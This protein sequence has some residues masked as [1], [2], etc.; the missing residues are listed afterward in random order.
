MAAIF[1][2]RILFAIS[3]NIEY[4]DYLNSVDSKESTFEYRLKRLTEENYRQS[5]HECIY[6]FFCC[7]VTDMSIH[8]H[9]LSCLHF[10]FVFIFLCM[11]VIIYFYIQLKYSYKILISCW[12]SF[13]KRYNNV[14][15][16]IFHRHHSQI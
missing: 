11:I 13:L 16:T 14:I 3:F 15:K 9:T 8:T 6:R 12:V 10:I 7:L 5:L 2:F 1:C 4:I